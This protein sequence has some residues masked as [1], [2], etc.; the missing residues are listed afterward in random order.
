MS[1]SPS[2][3]D[4]L[5][6]VI[7]LQGLLSVQMLARLKRHQR[8]VQVSLITLLNQVSS[9]AT[10]SLSQEINRLLANISRSHLHTND[11]STTTPP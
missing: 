3:D 6:E 5:E 2:F 10:P 8:D 7:L 9:Q 1:G 11:F 4:L